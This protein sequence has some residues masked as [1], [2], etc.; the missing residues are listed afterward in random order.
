MAESDGKIASLT[1][2]VQEYEKRVASLREMIDT[3]PEVETE[4]KRLNRDYS[5]TKQNYEALL[6]RQRV[7]ANGAKTSSKLATMCN[8]AS[9]IL[10]MSRRVHPAPIAC[11]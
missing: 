4:L 1:V 3:I 7:G 6:A 2:R 9:L 10:R 5:V 8:F 11:C